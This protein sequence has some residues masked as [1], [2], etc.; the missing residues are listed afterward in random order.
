MGFGQIRRV[1]EHK[2]KRGELMAFVDI[3]DDTGF[4]SLAC[5]PDLYRT[6]QGIIGKDK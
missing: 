3:Q 4:I 2:T 5:M 6:I 1:H